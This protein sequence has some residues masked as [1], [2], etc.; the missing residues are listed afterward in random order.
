MNIVQGK[1]CSEQLRKQCKVQSYLTVQVQSVQ[2]TLHNAQC[3]VY[4]VYFAHFTLHVLNVAFTVQ[5]IQSKKFIA[6]CT[7]DQL[8]VKIV[9]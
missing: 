2:F 6:E 5:N 8:T 1:V 7:L 9:H 4:S 3:T